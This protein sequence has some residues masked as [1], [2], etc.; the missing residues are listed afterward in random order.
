M[1]VNPLTGTILLIAIALALA[2]V[3]V[4]GVIGLC[5]LAAI[6]DGFAIVVQLRAGEEEV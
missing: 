1:T 5:L 2:G 6:N 3:T 4:Y